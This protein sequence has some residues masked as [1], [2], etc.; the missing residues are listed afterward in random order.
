MAKKKSAR[1]ANLSFKNK[2]KQDNAQERRAKREEEQ[3]RSSEQKSQEQERMRMVRQRNAM[4]QKRKRAQDERV[5]TVREA[6]RRSQ[7]KMSQLGDGISTATKSLLLLPHKPSS[8]FFDALNSQTPSFVNPYTFFPIEDME[9]ARAVVGAG[10][11]TGR[12][13]CS[14]EVQSW[15]PLFIPNTSGVFKKKLPG[16]TDSRPKVH[17]SYDFYSYEDLSEV[18]TTNEVM[19][20]EGPRR[21]IIPGS[22]LRG[23]IRSVYEQLTNSC[24]PM[25]DEKNKPLKRTALPKKPYRME[26]AH[27][28]ITGEWVWS[29]YETDLYKLGKHHHDDEFDL[30]YMDA[31]GSV[32]TASSPADTIGNK[33]PLE[34]IK[35]R[36]TSFAGGRYTLK[37]DVEYTHKWTKYAT[38]VTEPGPVAHAGSTEC[39]VH[40]TGEIG[41]RG[42]NH[43]HVTLYPVAR[44]PRARVV[45]SVSETDSVFRRF[46]RVVDSY[47]ADGTTTNHNEAVG[48]YKVYKS[49]LESRQ[50]V[51]VYVDDPGRLLHMSPSA[52][53]PESFDTQYADILEVQASH[54]PCSG[55]DDEFCPACRLF[56]MVGRDA[57]LG[58]RVR[59]SQGS[60]IGGHRFGRPTTLAPLSTP[61]PSSTEFYLRQ[62]Q[63]QEGMWNYDYL[64]VPSEGRRPPTKH[65]TAY[66]D[67]AG[68]GLQG[69]KVYLHAPFGLD[70]HYDKRQLQQTTQN[71]TVRPLCE[72]VFVFDVFFEGLSEEELANLA[73]AIGGT[74]G[75]LQKLGH[76]RPL[77]MGS[78]FVKVDSCSLRTYRFDAETGRLAST[79]SGLDDTRLRDML[80]KDARSVARRRLVNFFAQ[81]L[82]DVPF[83]GGSLGTRVQYPTSKVGKIGPDN[84]S[85]RW[86]VENRGKMN[87]PTIQWT[88]GTL[89]VEEVMASDTWRALPD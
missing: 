12:L 52:I 26:C 45:A 32:H 43:N 19:V 54:Q 14:L 80:P 10:T 40:I 37:V 62:P 57:V 60:L 16:H 51:L 53:S 71:V 24:L 6:R 64:L 46:L 17:R 44:D 61:R 27:D 11:L 83:G 86:F 67:L 15:S 82:A 73:F 1:G 77:G 22:E 13:T 47:C 85:F 70:K 42:R 25:I 74:N 84:E 5:K 39:Y 50:P 81:N 78:V 33:S 8:A 88:I 48:C 72:G 35:E 68:T 4:E 63:G 56:G 29:L 58:S 7:E 23:M 49:L 76:G 38:A 55:K 3:R 30:R 31:G 65:G 75:R 89:S 66:R 34:Y 28:P 59:V 36:Y 9:P 21:P 20:G 69:R 41:T 2:K 87:N 18:V 79:E